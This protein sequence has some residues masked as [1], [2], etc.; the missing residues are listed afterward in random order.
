MCMHIGV[1]FGGGAAQ[2]RA[3][4]KWEMPMHLSL[5]TT[6][7]PPQYFG[8]PAQYFWQ[9]YASVYAFLLFHSKG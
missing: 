7:C 1:D 2:A 6:F 4:N 3:P 5:L 8:L 9:V